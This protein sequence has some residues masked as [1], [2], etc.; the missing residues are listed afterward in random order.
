MAGGDD[1]GANCG[2]WRTVMTRGR[3]LWDRFLS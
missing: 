3:Q 2:P 1:E